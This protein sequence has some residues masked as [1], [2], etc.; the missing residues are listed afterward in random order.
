MRFSDRQALV[1]LVRVLQQRDGAL[2]GLASD[3]FRGLIRDV[4]FEIDF[5]KLDLVQS[6]PGCEDAG[7]RGA[8][9]ELS[10]WFP[11]EDIAYRTSLSSSIASGTVPFLMSSAKAAPKRL[12]K[13]P[14]ASVPLSASE[15]VL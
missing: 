14:M 13:P 4:S 9:R 10:R 6:V 15:V 1:R 7:K 3:V 12:G 11:S 8:V 2:K 5:G